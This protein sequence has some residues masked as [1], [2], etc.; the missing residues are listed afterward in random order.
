MT[1]RHGL[2]GRGTLFATQLLAAAGLGPG[3]MP[4]AHALPSYAR[5]TGQ[6][7]TAC[8]V[9]GFGPQLTPM[10]QKFKINGYTDSNGEG[11]D[12]PFSAM[13]VG[14]VTHTSKGQPG[15][16]GPHDGSNDNP[17]LQEVSA[18]VAGRITDH[19]GSFTQITYTDIDRA[20]AWDHLDVRYANQTKL[21]GQDTTVGV[22]LNNN[23]TVQDPFN[24]L[25][26]WGFPY[27]ASE[28]APGPAA[29][30]L[31]AGGL[32][33]QVAGLSAYGYWNDAIYAEAGAYRSLSKDFLTAVGQPAE[34]GHLRNL[35]PY[36]RLAYTGHPDRQY[37]S[38]G[39]Y[40]MHAAMTPRDGSAGSLSDTFD[41]VGIDGSYQFLGT[42]K[43]IV[44]LNGAYTHEWQNLDAAV[45]T[46][47]ADHR[48]NDL[49]SVN[50]NVA[51]YFDNTYGLT[52]GGF[53]VAG[54]RDKSLYA[55]GDIDGSRNGKPDSD[56]YQLQFDVTPFGKENSLAA[57]WLNVRMGVQYTGYTKFN[58][59]SHNYD[60]SG[61]NAS[62]N[63]T[64]FGFVWTSF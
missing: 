59:G 5:Q 27:E 9:G 61:R 21:F 42:R 38:V 14:S 36:W 3:L 28:L 44:T 24:T 13:V 22:D 56:G 30:P 19:I 40:G 35:A 46:G 57:P 55:V 43:H 32:E 16:A 37:Y 31:L 10:G 25:P 15:G 6:E 50:A 33:H 11:K 47:D 58:G 48:H 39:L 49:D 60:G 26:V 8:H 17:A 52:A 2:T 12:L 62:D 45:A 23:P 53:H 20:V 54:S 63:N 29:A 18:F 51:Y 41:D 4:S 7:C 64:L 1:D 34:A